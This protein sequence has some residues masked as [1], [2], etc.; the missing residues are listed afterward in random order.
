MSIVG[1]PIAVDD[2]L[3]SLGSLDIECDGAVGIDYRGGEFTGA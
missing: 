1:L 2:D 3:R